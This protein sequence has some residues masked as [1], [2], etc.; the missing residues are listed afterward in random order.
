MVGPELK[1]QIYGRDSDTWWEE[2][3]GKGGHRVAEDGVAPLASW[4]RAVVVEKAGGWEMFLFRSRG[5]GT[6]WWLA[7]RLAGDNIL[8]LCWMN[9]WLVLIWLLNT[10]RKKW[11]SRYY[12]FGSFE[13]LGR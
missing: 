8:R 4:D 9:S 13:W 3:P 1:N 2:R 11:F 6:H 12:L 7:L 5:S 10:S